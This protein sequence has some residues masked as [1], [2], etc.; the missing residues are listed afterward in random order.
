MSNAYECAL[1]SMSAKGM[2]LPFMDCKVLRTIKEG[3][4]TLIAL[5]VQNYNFIFWNVRT[6]LTII[7]EEVVVQVCGFRLDVLAPPPPKETICML[8]E[9]TFPSGR[10]N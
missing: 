2:H 3:E 6:F 1:L 9:Q 5:V 8:T 7:N 10:E 4:K